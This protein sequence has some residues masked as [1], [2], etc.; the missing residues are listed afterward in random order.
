M[1]GLPYFPTDQEIYGIKLNNTRSILKTILRETVQWHG[2]K[3]SPVC[4]C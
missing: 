2:L 4:S 1:L 3:D